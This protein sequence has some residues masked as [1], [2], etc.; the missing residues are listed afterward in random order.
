VFDVVSG[1][2]VLEALA[3]GF[4]MQAALSADQAVRSPMNSAGD[5]SQLELGARTLD[6]EFDQ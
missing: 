2:V 6:D 4:L 1:F 5:R 3:S